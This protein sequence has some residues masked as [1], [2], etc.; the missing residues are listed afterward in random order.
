MLG[1]CPDEDFDAFWSNAL[2]QPWGKAHPATRDKRSLK[3]T[4]PLVVHV[5]GIETFTNQEANVKSFSSCFTSG[6]STWDSKFVMLAVP[7]RMTPSHSL[8]RGFAKEICRFLSWSFGCAMQG[9][10]PTKGFYNEDWPANSWRLRASGQPIAGKHLFC[11]AGLKCD[12]K[13]RREVNN[14]K[15]HYGATDMCDQCMA[16]QLNKKACVDLNYGDFKSDSLHVDTDISHEGYLIMAG[17][18]PTTVIWR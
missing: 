18:D 16:Q 3:H 14:L 9:V 8:K 1:E 4:I 7:L 15:R 12:L 2:K 17:Q 10:M 5:D 11:F 6:C 13:A